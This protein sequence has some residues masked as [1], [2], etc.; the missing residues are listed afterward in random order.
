MEPILPGFL[1][2]CRRLITPSID[3]SD[4]P[5]HLLE[6]SR[7]F[8]DYNAY[9]TSPSSLWVWSKKGLREQEPRA[10]ANRGNLIY[11]QQAMM[12]ALEYGYMLHRGLYHRVKQ[13]RS[14][15]QV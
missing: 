12:E 10:D 8:E 2:E 14:T 1:R 6:G 15:D 11:E 4:A 3:Y 5:R 7:P 9:V 13:L